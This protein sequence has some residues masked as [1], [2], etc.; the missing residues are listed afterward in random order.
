MCV[1]QAQAAPEM[2]CHE[3]QDSV[4]HD[5][6]ML[7]KD[8]AGIDLAKSDNGPSIKAP[9][10]QPDGPLWATLADAAALKTYLPT[11]SIAIRGPPGWTRTAQI[12]P[13][14]I[15]TTQRFRI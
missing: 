4:D 14:L 5:A 12:H 15:L 10:I 2:P 3:Q 6:L 11:Q 9:D 13:P 8:C 1:K 7:L